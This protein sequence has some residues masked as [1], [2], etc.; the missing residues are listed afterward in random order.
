MKRNEPE[1]RGLPF[2]SHWDRKPSSYWRARSA[3]VSVHFLTCGAH[4]LGA[5]GEEEGRLALKLA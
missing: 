4:S 3:A 1:L 5:Q 2:P